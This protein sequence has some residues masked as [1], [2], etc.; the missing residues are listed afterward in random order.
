MLADP[1]TPWEECGIWTTDGPAVLMDSVTAGIELGVEY[2][3]GGDL[4]EQARVP[5]QS[6]SWMVRAVHAS[7]IDE[8]SVSVIQ[9]LPLA[10]S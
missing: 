1:F 10:T 5:L 6:G 9:L 3:N 7:T 4:P 8:T 2:P